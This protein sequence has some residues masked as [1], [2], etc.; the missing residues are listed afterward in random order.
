MVKAAIVIPNYNGIRYLNGCLD[1]LSACRDEAEF[2]IV[3]VD[4]GSADGSKELIRRQYPE[5]TL[6]ELSENTGFCH[7][8][9]VGIRHSEAPFVILLNNDT[10]VLKGFVKN[11]LTAM[12][13]DERL[14]AAGAQMLMWQ[15]HDRIDDA[16][17]QYCVLGWAYARGK[18]KKV[19]DF[20]KEAEIF[21]ACGGA[22]IYRREVLD[23]I[24]LLDENHF[25]YLEDLDICYRARIYGYRCL[26]VPKAKVL[27]AGS[28]TSGSKYNSFK[29]RLSSANSIYVIGK[30]MPVVQILWNLPFLLA[31]FLLKSLFYSYKKMG[32]LYLKGLCR[33]WKMSLSPQGRKQ[34]VRFQWKHL[35]NYLRIQ[36]LLYLNTVRLFRTKF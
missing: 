36:G 5:V 2:E 15:D 30:N 13:E 1:S 20:D 23:R 22:C 34:K 6:V 28:A 7:A 29:T 9:N 24:G 18:G 33:G 16:G 8:V 32:I 27:H 4:N 26:Y 11:L 25:A 21:A 19:S 3:I 17:D 14:F 35:K 12:E 31:G 10:V